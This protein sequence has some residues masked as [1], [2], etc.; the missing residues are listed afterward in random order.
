MSKAASTGKSRTSKPAIAKKRKQRSQFRPSFR[1][2]CVYSF[3]KSLESLQHIKEETDD[4]NVTGMA[5]MSCYKALSHSIEMVCKAT[6]EQRSS[7]LVLEDLGHFDTSYPKESALSENACGAKVALARASKIFK[8][9]FTTSDLGRLEKII[10]ARNCCE[11]KEFFI[12]DF[13]KEVHHIVKAMEIV[14]RVF[15]YQFRNGDLIEFSEKHSEYELKDI[16]E[17]MLLETS[18]EFKEVEEKAE[19]LKKKNTNFCR[20]ENCNYTFA[21]IASDGN[22][23]KCLWCGD[24]RLKKTC[25]V[26]TCKTIYWSPKDNPSLKCGRMHFE[27]SLTF[28]TATAAGSSFIPTL[29]N[30]N[31]SSLLNNAAILAGQGITL[32]P[33]DISPWMSMALDRPTNPNSGDSEPDTTADIKNEKPQK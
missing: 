3:A 12:Q 28:V 14:V 23:Y 7:Y 1:D 33:T 30:Q 8:S 15:D 17:Q 6:L 27:D 11:H 22:S 32:S 9:E 29:L 4:A 25:S 24:E 31:S 13:D 19:R 16:Y 2:R 10:N 26:M 5:F 20:C 21:E 18:N